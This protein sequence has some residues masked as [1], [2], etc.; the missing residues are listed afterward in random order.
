MS[1]PLYRMQKPTLSDGHTGLWYDKFCDTWREEQRAF[2]LV[3]AKKTDS[4]GRAA[5]PKEQW[6][7]TVTEAPVGMAE[8]LKE[9]DQRRRELIRSHSGYPIFVRTA[10]RFVT[11]LGNRHPVENGFTWHPVL[12]T[13]YLPGSGCKGVA[14][15]WAE[16]HLGDGVSQ[17]EIDRIFGPRKNGG[18]GNNA[19]EA[20]GAAE[21]TDCRAGS[22]IFL[23]G[24]PIMPVLL[25]VDVMT[26]HYGAYYHASEEAL[27]E[28]RHAPADW[29]APTPIPFLCVAQCTSFLFG[30][31]PM[32]PKD[33]ADIQDAQRARDWLRDALSTIGAGAKTAVGYGRFERDSQ[34]EEAARK[35]EEKRAEEERRR[36]VGPLDL[37]REETVRM[38]EGVL[39]QRAVEWLAKGQAPDEERKRLFRQALS[40][41]RYVASWRKGTPVDRRQ[42]QAGEKK[43]KQMA[44][45]VMGES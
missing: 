6:I 40:E 1:A 31:L 45:L 37:M 15:T 33:P 39:Y 30:V 23:D 29:H 12:G 35:E 10:C 14:R 11:G 3:A 34:R 18:D 43:L 16:M 5:S 25:K 7:K 19:S 36:N 20:T 32:R 22:V 41:T 9:F 44:K 8:R 28:P 26:P 2:A 17:A 21:A 42:I 13:P 24:F 27:K 38:N 4:E